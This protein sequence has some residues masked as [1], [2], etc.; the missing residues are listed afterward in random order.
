[1]VVCIFVVSLSVSL[2]LSN[3]FL[4]LTGSRPLSCFSLTSL[5]QQE[6]TL[7]F[8]GSLFAFLCL[9]RVRVRVGGYG[10]DLEFGVWVGVWVEGQGEGQGY[11]L[12]FGLGFRF[13]VDG[14]GFRV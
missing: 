12:W 1:M 9:Q 14:L 5:V 3:S 13:G 8:G 11:G 4:L 6:S 2:H 7:N 10:Y